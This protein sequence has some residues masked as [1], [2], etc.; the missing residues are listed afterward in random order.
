[1]YLV[2]SFSNAIGSA[3]VME[4]PLQDVLDEDGFFLEARDEEQIILSIY[5]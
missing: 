5:L 1:M 4:I 2:P 3:Q